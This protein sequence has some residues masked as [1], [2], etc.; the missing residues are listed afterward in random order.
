MRVGN[1][2]GS[3]AVEA[4]EADS[5]DVGDLA[6]RTVTELLG[7]RQA[8][9]RVAVLDAYLA[10]LQP[11]SQ[12][13][14]SSLVHVPA[15]T[16]LEKSVARARAVADLV[17]VRPGGAVAVIGVV[18]SLLAALGERGAHRVPCDLRG[19]TTEWGEPVTTDHR[20][21]ISRADAVLASGMVLGN[22]TF[23]E[24]SA[25]CRE[26]GLALVVFAQTGS[27]V[28]RELVG[29]HVHALSAEPYPFFW[30]TGDGTDIHTY[31]AQGGDATC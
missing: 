28:L 11:H 1:A 9:V 21:A 17:P 16:S 5:L 3:C 30:L 25:L 15:G 2:V 13:P 14:R 24:I 6:G 23:D 10:W 29:T 31:V 7:H 8:P 19:G 12:H 22:G 18:N 27:A 4:G 26:R 20:E